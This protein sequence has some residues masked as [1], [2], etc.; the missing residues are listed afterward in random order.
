MINEAGNAG[1][2]QIIVGL[3]G[4]KYLRGGLEKFIG[5]KGKLVGFICGFL[6]KDFQDIFWL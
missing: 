4:N 2:I 5:C 1:W 6:A 3:L